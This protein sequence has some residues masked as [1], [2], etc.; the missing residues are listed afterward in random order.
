MTHEE[1]VA[2]TQAR[3]QQ[4]EKLVLGESVEAALE[5]ALVDGVKYGQRIAIDVSY[6]EKMSSFVSSFR[7]VY[8]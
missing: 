8:L 3:L 7:C 5:A 2:W 6:Q 1:R 4:G